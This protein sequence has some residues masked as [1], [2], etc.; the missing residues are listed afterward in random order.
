MEDEEVSVEEE[1]SEEKIIVKNFAIQHGLV[2]VAQEEEVEVI[3]FL[4]DHGRESKLVPPNPQIADKINRIAK[5]LLRSK[6]INQ[7]LN[8]AV[9]SFCIATSNRVWCST[10][11]CPTNNHAVSKASDGKCA[12]DEGMISNQSLSACFWSNVEVKKRLCHKY[13]PSYGSIYYLSFDKRYGNI[14][15][16]LADFIPDTEWTEDFD[17]ESGSID[18]GP[19]MEISKLILSHNL[20]NWGGIF[21]EGKAGMD[22]L[23]NIIC[24]KGHSVKTLTD[25]D[26]EM[27][28]GEE[29]HKLW[30]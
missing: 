27:M 22:A 1:A 3:N 6:T 5:C 11:T 4:I 15:P 29:Y 25:S 19:G 26:L 7:I 28:V 23:I 14:T 30:L 17:A 24:N 18:I 16:S 12:E 13:W 10:W 21:I 20:K 2:G 8:N 9:A